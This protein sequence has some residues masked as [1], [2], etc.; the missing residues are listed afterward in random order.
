[1]LARD[2]K[3]D[4]IRLERTNMV[5]KM[6][7]R[8]K[9]DLVAMSGQIR[10]QLQSFDLESLSHTPEMIS[11][12]ATQFNQGARSRSWVLLSTPRESAAALSRS[13]ATPRWRSET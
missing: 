3:C 2:C 6:E 13:E 12:L 1:M 8:I 4:L 11:R 10:D 9:I 5:T 7:D